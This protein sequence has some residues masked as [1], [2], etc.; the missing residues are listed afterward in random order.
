MVGSIPMPG[1]ETWKLLLSVITVNMWKGTNL[2]KIPSLCEMNVIMEGSSVT[3]SVEDLRW[4]FLVGDCVGLMI[5]RISI[6]DC[7]HS[8]YHQH[9]RSCQGSA[10]PHVVQG[11]FSPGPLA[12]PHST[13]MQPLLFWCIH[14]TLT[15]NRDI[16]SPLR[17]TGVC[18]DAGTLI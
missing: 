2:L 12:S 1:E 10:C 9:L 17:Y 3:N 6:R 8:Y 15:L 13:D 18:M 4:P 7:S 14:V 16:P 11:G 5:D